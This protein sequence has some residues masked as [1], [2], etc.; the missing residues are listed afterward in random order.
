MTWRQ[1]AWSQAGAQQAAA[2][3]SASLALPLLRDRGLVGAGTLVWRQPPPIRRP[4]LEV[5]CPRFSPLPHPRP[6]P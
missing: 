1:V 3:P 4:I 2:H 6:W 5:S